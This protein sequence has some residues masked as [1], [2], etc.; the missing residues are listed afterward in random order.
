MIVTQNTGAIKYSVSD[1]V[2]EKGTT[3]KR[4]K[5][6]VNVWSVC[7]ELAIIHEES[8]SS[9]NKQSPWIYYTVYF[10]ENLFKI[11]A[12]VIYGT[13]THGH[14]EGIWDFPL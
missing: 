8:R 10:D 12:V 14:P 1:S 6:P 3:V 4:K 2:E 9:T 7:E 13:C 5:P 11:E